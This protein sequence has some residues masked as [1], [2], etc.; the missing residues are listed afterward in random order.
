[1]NANPRLLA[2]HQ[3]VDIDGLCSRFRK[4]TPGDIYIEPRVGP[5]VDGIAEL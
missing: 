2:Y 3:M 5:L 1:M 4:L